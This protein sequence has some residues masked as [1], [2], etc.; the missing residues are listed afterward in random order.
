MF[1]K[2]T[3]QVSFLW[4]KDIL[5]HSIQRSREQGS[6]CGKSHC[7]QVLAMGARGKLVAEDREKEL[8]GKLKIWV[9]WWKVGDWQVQWRE[10]GWI[11]SAP[12]AFY[13]PVFSVYSTLVFYKGTGPAQRNFS[14]LNA[15]HYFFLEKSLE[16]GHLVHLSSIS[17]VAYNYSFTLFSNPKF[18]ETEYSFYIPGLLWLQN[19]IFE[20]LENFLRIF[21]SIRQ[22]YRGYTHTHN[23]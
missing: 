20:D 15:S 2:P 3:F 14:S 4:W 21:T 9:E 1:L 10:N 5:L 11:L 19:L 8:A 17:V 22:R 13:S 18:Q 16:I 12:L 6:V 7:L 23:H